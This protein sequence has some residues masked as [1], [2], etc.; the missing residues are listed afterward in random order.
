M[1]AFVARAVA[2]QAGRAARSFDGRRHR[3]ASPRRAIRDDVAR[4]GLFDAAGVRFDDNRFGERRAG[5][6]ESVRRHRRGV[7]A[8]ATSTPCSIDEAV[9]P[10]VPWPASQGLIARRRRDAAFEQAVLDRIGRGAERFLPGEEAAQH[11]PARVAAVVPAGCGDRSQRARRCTLRGF[12]RRR[13]CCS[14]AAATCRIMERPDAVAAAVT[15][16]IAT[17]V[18]SNEDQARHETAQ[19]CSS[20]SHAAARAGRVPARAKIRKCAARRAGRGE[21]TG[22]AGD[23]Q[24]VR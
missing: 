15:S 12:R 8:S 2:G 20:P 6:R 19:A 11:P 21:G 24:A 16:L 3:R 7:T 4:V 1:T 22:G 18:D 23:R 5:R 13:R 10:R 14:M 9:K 17:H